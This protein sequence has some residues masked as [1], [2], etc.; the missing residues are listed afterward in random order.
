MSNIRDMIEITKQELIE[1]GY[2]EAKAEA[3]AKKEAAET[4]EI[5]QTML[6]ER[7][8]KDDDLLLLED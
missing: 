1:Q 6:R 2:S 3:E 8:M 4:L 5:Y 7:F